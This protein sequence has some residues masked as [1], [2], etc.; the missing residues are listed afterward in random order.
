MNSLQR[1]IHLNHP[2]YTLVISAISKVIASQG[3][4]PWATTTSMKRVRAQ[5][6]DA[7]HKRQCF[8]Q[9]LQH[10][11]HKAQ[12]RLGPAPRRLDLSRAAC[13]IRFKIQD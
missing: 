13:S 11:R 12:I 7:A 8:A 3:A 5:Q 4:S 10:P 9:R 2:H 6:A 1:R